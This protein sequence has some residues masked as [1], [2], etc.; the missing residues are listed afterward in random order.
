MVSQRTLLLVTS[1]LLLFACTAAPPPP[2]VAGPAATEEQQRFDVD[3][4]RADL[5]ALYAGLQS[6]HYDLYAYRTK[7]AYDA[8]YAE[9]RASIGTS[10]S[11]LDVV[12]LFQPF[13][14]FGRVGHARLEFPVAGYRAAAQR[15][16]KILPFDLRFLDG[17]AFVTHNYTTDPRLSPG[18]EIVALD[19]RPILEVRE[20]VARYVSGERD[21]LVDA[22]LEEF[23]PRWLWVD[24][25]SI[26]SFTIAVRTRQ[27]VENV[28]VAGMTIAAAEKS[29]SGWT[30]APHAREVQLRDDGVA[31]L[32][33][34]PFY[35]TEG[36]D[37]MDTRAFTAFV[38]DA[39]GRIIAA[40]SRAVVIDVRNNP[41]GDNSF[42]DPLVAW[43]ADE[44]FRFS[45]DFRI[46]AS[47]ETADAY[48]NATDGIAKAMYEA[49]LKRAPGE[50]FLFELPFAQPRGP[51]RFEGCVYVLTN[52]HSYSNSASMAALVQDYRFGRILG[53]ETADLPTSYASSVQFTLPH[54]GIAVTYPKSYFVRPN[55]DRS[56]RGVVPDIAIPSPR[57]GE[58]GDTML[59]KALAIAAEQCEP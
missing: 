11:M 46:K 5:A 47:P 50:R 41:G 14:A 49:I 15:Q 57:A 25:G 34:G 52:R 44:P 31:W 26:D 54:T 12:R 30:T 17:R 4:V 38:D 53:E 32:R 18:A 27:G 42:S 16:E 10:S 7:E 33:P 29:K 43:F 6:A 13:V 24:R 51:G 3:E 20:D 9:T 35:N 58:S 40:G 59:Q 37:S 56:V 21:Y 23:F 22:Q 55:G 1:A 28:T 36:G 45:N 39:F 2:P 8:K 19:G 48:R